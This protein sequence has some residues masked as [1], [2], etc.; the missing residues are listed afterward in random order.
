MASITL[1]LMF[2]KGCLHYAVCTELGPR[3]HG[4]MCYWYP[5]RPLAQWKFHGILERR[6]SIWATWPHVKLLKASYWSIS[7]ICLIHQGQDWGETGEALSLVAK[8]KHGI[9]GDCKHLSNSEKQYFN[10]KCL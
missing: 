2:G 5:A 8:S 3:S 9:E 4:N 1:F 6:G 7:H 10:P